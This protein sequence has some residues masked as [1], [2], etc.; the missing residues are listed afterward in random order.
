M[1]RKKAVKRVPKAKKLQQH[2]GK[3]KYD[4]MVKHAQKLKRGGKSPDEIAESLKLNF[5][6]VIHP[7]IVFAV[8]PIF[9]MQEP[10][11]PVE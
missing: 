1:A 2:V 8:T 4:E 5:P 7:L 10:T 3:K 6:E 11:E 9:L